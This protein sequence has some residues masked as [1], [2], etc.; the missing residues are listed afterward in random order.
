MMAKFLKKETAID[1]EF[2]RHFFTVLMTMLIS[3]YLSIT[4]MGWIIDNID[5]SMP[6]AIMASVYIILFIAW[7]KLY[8]LSKEYINDNNRASLNVLEKWFVP[9]KTTTLTLVFFTSITLMI[10]IYN[11]LFDSISLLE[12][13]GLPISTLVL[14]FIVHL[15]IRDLEP[16]FVKIVRIA[17]KE[18]C[19]E[20]AHISTL[21]RNYWVQSLD[22]PREVIDKLLTFIDYWLYN[23]S[24]AASKFLRKIGPEGY[25]LLDDYDKFFEGYSNYSIPQ[26]M[27]KKLCTYAIRGISVKQ[28]LNLIIEK[29]K[30]K[31]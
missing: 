16:N 28:A 19:C 29:K 18:F 23:Q 11:Y 7:R 4:Y 2:L 21:A 24:T 30:Y 3:I 22:D 8:V 27:I 14:M 10:L 9:L 1:V 15:L 26:A 12:L 31:S 25:E 5:I 13:I 6:L 17:D 20:K